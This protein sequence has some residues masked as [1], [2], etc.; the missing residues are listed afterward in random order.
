VDIRE[1][2]IGA[3]ISIGRRHTIGVNEKSAAA[4]WARKETARVKIT[5]AGHGTVAIDA[6]SGRNEQSTATA[7]DVG[8]P[9]LAIL[10]SSRTGA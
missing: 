9:R 6:G 8:T 7:G 3:W 1:G 10:S 2:R 5:A 4:I